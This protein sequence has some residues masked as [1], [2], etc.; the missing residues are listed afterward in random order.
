M[1]LKVIIIVNVKFLTSD[2]FALRGLGLIIMSV[3]Q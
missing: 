3:Q 1:T 2:R